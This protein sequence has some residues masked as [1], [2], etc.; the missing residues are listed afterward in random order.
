M[1]NDSFEAYMTPKGIVTRMS[2]CY[3]R[4]C[5]YIQVCSWIGIY[6]GN[7]GKGEAAVAQHCENPTL[8]FP[9]DLQNRT[10]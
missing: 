1:C 6:C 3:C 8:F 2:A 10:K 7:C 5:A 4:K 9:E